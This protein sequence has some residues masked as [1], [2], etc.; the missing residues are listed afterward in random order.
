MGKRV[1]ACH[2][3]ERVWGDV[4]LRVLSMG[5]HVFTCHDGERVWGDTSLR[6]LSIG[7]RVFTCYDEERLWE[8]AFTCFKHGKTCLYVS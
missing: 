4:S 6:V 3:G 8:P 1:F 5:R 7:K 2:D